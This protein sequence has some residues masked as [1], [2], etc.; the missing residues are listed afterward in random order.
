MAKANVNLLRISPDIAAILRRVAEER[1]LPEAMVV[2]MLVIKEAM[3]KGIL[4]ADHPEAAFWSLVTVVEGWAIPA[5]EHYTREVFSRINS[6]PEARRLWEQAT[7]GKRMKGV[8]QK[9][10]RFC[11]FLTGWESAGQV[12]IRRDSGGLIT[13]YSKL[14]PPKHP[15]PAKHD[16]ID[17]YVR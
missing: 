6:T 1:H 8:N 3:E 4:G 5:Q 15:V 14:A 7:I 9:L 12:Q 11:K 2:E 16:R 13:S 10:G 17:L